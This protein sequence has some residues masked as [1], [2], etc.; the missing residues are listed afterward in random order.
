MELDIANHRYEHIVTF[1]RPREAGGEVVMA[2]SAFEGFIVID[3][4][5]SGVLATGQRDKDLVLEVLIPIIVVINLVIGRR[6]E[7]GGLVSATGCIGGRH[8]K[9]IGKGGSG[10]LR[11]VL[12]VEKRRYKALSIAVTD[13]PV[14]KTVPKN[15]VGYEEIFLPNL[16]PMKN[17]GNK[18]LKAVERLIGKGDLV[19]GHDV[20]AQ[21]RRKTAH[22]E[23]HFDVVG[24]VE[25]RALGPR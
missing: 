16:D 1:L 3:P 23:R 10:F 25:A 14:L 11:I 20:H 18:R 19:T 24:K 6:S 13:N 4:V 21:E 5:I 22:L 2:P 15:S 12:N 8:T 7:S 17:R 9:I